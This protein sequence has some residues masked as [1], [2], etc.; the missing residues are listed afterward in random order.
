MICRSLAQCEDEF[1]AGEITATELL[2]SASYIYG[3]AMDKKMA[4]IKDSIVEDIESQADEL[5][6]EA[7]QLE[8]ESEEAVRQ[9]AENMNWNYEEQIVWN[10]M[11][12]EERRKKWGIDPLKDVIICEMCDTPTESMLLISCGCQGGCRTC[13]DTAMKKG[14]KCPH[15]N[16]GKTFD[17]IFTICEFKTKSREQLQA[18]KMSQELNT[19]VRIS[20]HRHQK[21]YRRKETQR[22]KFKKIVKY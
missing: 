13:Y 11:G 22:S 2:D 4:E 9:E 19:M 18:E 8:R 21:H 3:A 17:K 15:P 14:S 5:L 12:I 16:C 7:L 1:N 6:D 20:H 10:V